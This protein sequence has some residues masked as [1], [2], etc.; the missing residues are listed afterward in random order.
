MAKVPSAAE[1][2]EAPDFPRI[3]TA[4]PAAGE[5]LGITTVPVTLV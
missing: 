2:V 3:D 1:V 4:A 5:P